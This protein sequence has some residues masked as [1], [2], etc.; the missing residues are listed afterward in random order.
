MR[1]QPRL[2][3][4]YGRSY[5]CTQ[6]EGFPDVWACWGGWSDDGTPEYELHFRGWGRL[7][8]PGDPME[9]LALCG[10]A[11][12]ERKAVHAYDARPVNWSEQEW[13]GFRAAAADFVRAV[14]AR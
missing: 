2:T 9:A 10:A 14:K 3:W 11:E 4:S 7:I 8:V 13:S 1:I 6:P 12:A 5:S